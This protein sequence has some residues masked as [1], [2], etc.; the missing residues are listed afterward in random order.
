MQ[1]TLFLDDELLFR[2]AS[3]RALAPDDSLVEIEFADME[4]VEW[5]ELVGV[6]PLE[7]AA[8]IPFP[9]LD[10]VGVPPAV[11]VTVSMPFQAL[12]PRPFER[13]ALLA[14]EL[15]TEEYEGR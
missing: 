13:R 4:V 10:F 15:P 8:M 6:R 1:N 9:L 12:L 2:R 3:A 14:D 11:A 7:C 5:T